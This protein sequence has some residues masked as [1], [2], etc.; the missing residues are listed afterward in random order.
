MK[1]KIGFFFLFA[2]LNSYSRVIVFLIDAQKLSNNL[3]T[4]L[5]KQ[6]QE[7]IAKDGIV[8]AIPFC[9][10]NLGSKAK[11]AAGEEML[12]K[13]E[14]GRTSHLIRN[15]KNKPQ[16]WMDKYLTDFKGKSKEQVKQSYLVHKL[17]GGK[18]VYLEPLYVGPLCLQC[19]GDKVAPEVKAQISKL[20]PEDKATGFKL[21][22]FRGF[23]W[24]KEK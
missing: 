24:V 17:D 12:K 21:G 4:N 16:P 7:K 18:R 15:P 10:A 14:F 11:P 8:N 9:H 6:L 5:Q 13:Y 2:S 1:K 19:H 20:Y 22:E 3:K 23:I